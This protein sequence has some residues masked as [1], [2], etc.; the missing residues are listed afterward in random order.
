M[1]NRYDSEISDPYLLGRLFEQFIIIET[2][3]W[4]RQ[5]QKMVN[6]YYWRTNS[7]AEVDLLTEQAGV[8]TG[9]YEIKWSHTVDTAHLS[10]LRSFQKDYPDVPCHVVCNVDEPYRLGNVQVLNW[11]QFLQGLSTNQL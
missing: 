4:I 2:L 11:K 6:L 5:S 9:A 1:I 3:K 7:G 8:L 10:G